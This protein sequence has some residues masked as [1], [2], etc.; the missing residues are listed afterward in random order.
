MP[1]FPVN[2]WG[3]MLLACTCVKSRARLTKKAGRNLM[4]TP[5]GLLIFVNIKETEPRGMDSYPALL[6]SGGVF[7]QPAG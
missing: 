3:N 2:D 1:R 6:K 7:E 4:P 5:L